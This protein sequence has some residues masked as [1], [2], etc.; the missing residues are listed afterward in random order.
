MVPVV[1]YFIYNFTGD[2][3]NT[4]LLIQEYLDV[5]I[6]AVNT[7]YA[8]YYPNLEPDKYYIMK[9]RNPPRMRGTILPQT[10]TFFGNVL[11]PTAAISISGNHH[12]H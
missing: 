12:A 4:D 9:G 6:Q 8:K 7:Y 11:I 3:M 2:D 10:W 5:L 1:L